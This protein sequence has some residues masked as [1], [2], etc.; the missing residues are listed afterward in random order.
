LAVQLGTV[1][2]CA[3]MNLVALA[4]LCAVVR[5]LKMRGHVFL[6]GLFAQKRVEKR[7]HIERAPSGTL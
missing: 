2:D 5:H 7:R 6:A 4:D 3:E 1:D